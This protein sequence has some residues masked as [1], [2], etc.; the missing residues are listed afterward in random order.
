VLDGIPLVANVVQNPL[1]FAQSSSKQAARLEL[2]AD[3]PIAETLHGLELSPAP[4]Q[5]QYSPVNEAIL[6]AGR[7]LID[8]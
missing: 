4:L 7:N 5:Y 3:H 1:E 6:F 8:R 2:G